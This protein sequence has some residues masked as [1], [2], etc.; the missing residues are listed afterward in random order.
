MPRFILFSCVF[1]SGFTALVFQVVWQK[2]LAQILG[3]EARS[4]SLVVAI[5]LLGLATGYWAWGRLTKKTWPRHQLLKIYGF[6]E[7]AIGFYA[8]A[9]PIGFNKVRQIIHLFPDLLFMDFLLTLAL[10]FIPTFFMGAGIPLLTVTLPKN[11]DEINKVHAKIYGINTLG[12]FFGVITASFYLIPQW[13]LFMSMGVFG[14]CNVLIGLVFSLNR[15]SGKTHKTAEVPTV[16]RGFPPFLVYTFTFV[17]GSTTIALEI[18]FM[19][20]FSLTTGAGFWVFP[21]ILG[22]FILGLGVGSLTLPKNFSMKNLNLH[23]LGITFFSIFL[24]WSIPHWPYWVHHIR[25][26]LSNLPPAFLLY[27][28]LLFLFM[29]IMTLPLIILLGRLLPVSYSLIKKT[30]NNFGT[31][32]GRLYFFNTLGTVF[33]SVVCGYLA[34]ALFQLDTVIRLVFIGTILIF[35]L[36]TVYS[37]ALKTGLFLGVGLGLFITFPRWDR[38]SH[39]LGLFRH[40]TP[41]EYSFKGFFKIPKPYLNTGQLI[42]FEDG[43]NTTVT[44]IGHKVGTEIHKDNQRPFTSTSFIVNGKSDGDTVTDFPTAAGSALIP[45]LFAPKTPNLK[46]LVVGMGTGITSNWLSGFKDMK[47]VKT[48]EISKTVLKAAPFLDPYNGGLTTKSKHTF[49]QGDA[50]RYFQRFKNKKVD[51]I[52]SEPSNPWVS[53]VE[54]LYTKDFYQLVSKQLNKNGI[55]FQW[56]QGYAFSNKSFRLILQNLTN[57]FKDYRVYKIGIGDFALLASSSELPKDPLDSRLMEPSVV[58]LFSKLGYKPKELPLFQIMDKVFIQLASLKA[59]KAKHTL[60]NP[61]LHFM[62]GLD[63]YKNLIINPIKDLEIEFL[64][65]SDIPGVKDVLRESLSKDFSCNPRTLNLFPCQFIQIK[66]KKYREMIKQKTSTDLKK[67]LSAYHLL[68]QNAWIPPDPDFLG[69]ALTRFKLLD[70]NKA[71]D[72]IP[73][74]VQQIVFEGQ[75][76]KAINKIKTWHRRGLLTRAKRNSFIRT[77]QESDSLLKFLK[78]HKEK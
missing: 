34:L 45:Y 42:Y 18:L 61:K 69:R 57:N 73:I 48:L 6:M 71:P 37:K 21:M 23:F 10:L 9:F 4:V 26:L 12:A 41:E 19:R 63:F 50:F 64:R 76:Q 43:P 44:V 46:A 7:M 67:A 72:V 59:I 62:A 24:F 35:I 30:G 25:I 66:K 16:G 75:A 52:I 40:R 33:G 47:S 36:M 11:T 29:G 60:D 58:E 56:L 39:H 55:L 54:N 51:I 28:I 1:V 22:T 20:V 14:A 5:F 38:G 13:G 8:I 65:H 31:I 68:R 49:I 74:L 53:G 3:A 15:L 17:T 32:C 70:K 27:S 2:Y 78:R 77:I